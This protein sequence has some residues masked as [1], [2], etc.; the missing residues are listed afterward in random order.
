M[1]KYYA[2]IMLLL[3]GM[4]TIHAQE[5]TKEVKKKV[6]IVKKEKGADGKV[7]ETRVEAEG[8][9][10]DALLKEMKENGK[11]E[12]IDI[13]IDTDKKIR[14]ITKS[15]STTITKT[16]GKDGANKREVEVKVETGDHNDDHKTVKVIIKSDDGEEVIEWKGDG[17]M[18]DDI[19]KKLKDK[20]ID[21]VINSDSKKQYRIKSSDGKMIEWD[22]EGEMPEEIKNIL[23]E[24][25]IDVND[26][27][28]NV[29]MF[30]GDKGGVKTKKKVFMFKSDTDLDEDL[31]ETSV[32]LGVMI[33]G[34]KLIIEDTVE[35]ASAS[36]AGLKASDRITEIN[37]Y[38]VLNYR[39]LIT[40]LSKYN[41]DDEIEV[42]YLREGK[43]ASAKV[44]LQAKK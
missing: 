13:E 34:S 3:L 32:S 19:K 38:G 20:D 7:T 24:H 29:Y 8:D 1:K 30:K 33:A 9:E 25:D 12:N 28:G 41:P 36:M 31:P 15:N 16:K 35:N 4:A 26:H 21:V 44:K 37:G 40:E 39:D 5:E 23:E 10:A 17:E 6:V 14:K 43:A 22:G 2:M 27:D 18:P 11:L 42:R